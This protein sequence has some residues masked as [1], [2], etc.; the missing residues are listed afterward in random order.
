MGL[1]LIPI[2]FAVCSVGPGLVFLHHLRW[3]PLEKLAACIG[4]SGLLVYL[5]A[6][7]TYVMDLDPFTV[8]ASVSAAAATM[9]IVRRRECLAIL[10]NRRVRGVLSAWVVLV[11]WSIG[12]L[13]LVRHYSGA[14]WAGDWLEH[15][16]RTL[17]FLEHQPLDTRFIGTWHLTARP[18]LANLVAAHYLPLVE[19]GFD[20]FQLV[21]L[22]LNQAVFIPAAL[23]T[24]LF[25]RG[26]RFSIL[27]LLVLFMACPLFLQNSTYTVTKLYTTFYVILAVW[28]YLAGWRK[29]DR[30]RVAAAFVA[31]ATGCLV[32]Y[33]AG[34]YAL[35]MLL[36]YLVAVWPGRRD[37]P[38][39][40]AVAG[41]GTAVLCTWFVWAIVHFGLR[42]ALATNSTIAD[43][44]RRS[45]G[46]NAVK[47]LM[48]LRDTV[49]PAPFRGVPPPA[50]PGG[51]DWWLWLREQA[52]AVYQL[53]MP[54]AMGSVGGVLVLVLAF[55]ELRKARDG[56][57]MFWALLLPFAFIV[58]VAVHGGRDVRGLTHISLQPLV[59]LGLGLLAAWLP[60][61]PRAVAAALLA[62]VTADFVL[63]V[64]L[65][66]HF[67][68]A[69]FRF[70]ALGRAI[71][72]VPGTQTGL[73]NWAQ[74]EL[75]SLVYLGDSCASASAL[76]EPLVAAMFAVALVMAAATWQR[77]RPGSL[78]RRV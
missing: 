75:R 67:Q 58:G 60:R 68:R 62:G 56:E 20:R 37:G 17:F 45:P 43:T 72:V 40:A 42:G 73:N 51:D 6:L 35:F 46:R 16:E 38:E 10:A 31:M 32:H 14:E 69:A 74:K 27:A 23:M 39:L 70:D 57:P 47:V 78:P 26:R 50:L 4:L 9:L 49:L 64:L 24:R 29:R 52:F 12:L 21:F 18:P 30:V 34:P 8:S 13:A 66:F 5:A 22:L 55:R 7:G 11:A 48:N 1:V 65:H 15:Y 33:S 77:R 71:A 25:A 41:G 76:I 36:H 19:R 3:H 44:A 53:N 28:L 61:L 2:L 59:V 63:G 54:F